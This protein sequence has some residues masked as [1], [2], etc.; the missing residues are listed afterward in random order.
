MRSDDMVR[1]LY[2]LA[3]HGLWVNHQ[4]RE[5]VKSAAK[6]IAEQDLEII[7]LKDKLTAAE[8]IKKPAVTLGVPDDDF[9]E[10]WWPVKGGNGNDT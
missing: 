3:A 1:A 6:R 2:G 8:G 10:D 7:A 9:W 5:L 4:E